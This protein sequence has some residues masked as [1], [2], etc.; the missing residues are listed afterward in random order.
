MTLLLAL[1]AALAVTMALIPPLMR[2]ATAMQVVDVPDDR[3]V[4]SVP[5]PRIGGIAMVA[6]TL[7]SVLVWLP[8]GDVRVLSYVLGACTIL[9]FGVWD[10]RVSLPPLAKI[11]GQL[12]AIG[13]VVV[14]GG[15]TIEGYTLAERHTLT[16]CIGTT[17]TVLFFLGVINAINLSDGLDGLAGGTTLLS[18]VALGLLARATGDPAVAVIALALAG[19][20]LGFLRFNTYPARIFMGDGGSQFLGFTIAVLSVLLTQ[21]EN[22]PL[23]TALPVMLL[24]LPVIDTLMVMSQ[25]LREGHSIFRADKRHIHHKLLARGFDH[26][27]SVLLIY[28]AHAVFFVLAWRMRYE[29]DSY[30][31]LTFFAV[32]GLIVAMLIAA[33]RFDW[34]WRRP[35]LR[36]TGRSPLGRAVIWL[37]QAARLPR[38]ALL[39]TVIC[40]LAYLAAVAAPVIPSRDI[41]LL[42]IVIVVPMFASL[43][44]PRLRQG[45]QWIARAVLAVTVTIA[46]YL[47][48]QMPDPPGLLHIIKLVALPVLGVCVILRMRLSERRFEITTLDVLLVF[49]AIVVPNLPGVSGTQSDLAPSFLKYVVLLYAVELCIDQGP[50]SRRAVSLGALVFGVALLART[51]L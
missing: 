44:L 4:H 37:G 50:G 19:S 34:H 1:V 29:P 17:L 11:G 10:D 33:G 38:W 6:G 8:G 2:R 42:A 45:E 41:A 26:Y 51:F 25:R 24:G 15:I 13:I 28:S 36:A 16:P 46:V 5:I 43:W 18:A 23:S 35:A 31:V 12:I 9:A 27:E 3:R 32:A 21:N 40:V 48:H 30:I 49:I 20:I 47:D 14:F 39:A 7:L 22:V